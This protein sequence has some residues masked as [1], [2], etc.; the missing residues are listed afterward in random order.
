MTIQFC[1]TS[2]HHGTCPSGFCHPEWSDSWPPPHRLRFLLL[3][4]HWP[5]SLNFSV[6]H[7]QIG[8][9]EE[10]GWKNNFTHSHHLLG[11]KELKPDM[12]EEGIWV[13]LALFEKERLCLHFQPPLPQGGVFSSLVTSLSWFLSTFQGMG[14]WFSAVNSLH[15]FLWLHC[16]L[17]RVTK[18]ELVDCPLIQLLERVGAGERSQ[19]SA[20]C[21]LPH[22]CVSLSP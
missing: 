14:R 19:S 15:S 9:K 20:P 7:V 8:W 4:L 12:G 18:Q 11:V 3:L 21:Y 13:L 2:I 1:K 22:L 10:R 6:L 5:S 17:A 16:K